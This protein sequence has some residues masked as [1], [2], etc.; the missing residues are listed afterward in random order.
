[1]THCAKGMSFLLRSWVYG[2]QQGSDDGVGDEMMHEMA[3]LFA[4]TLI[5]IRAHVGSVQPDAHQSVSGGDSQL[6]DRYVLIKHCLIHL[7]CTKS[8][9]LYCI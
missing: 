8:S 7:L 1:M 4:R 3:L 2:L 9:H 5:L 6:L